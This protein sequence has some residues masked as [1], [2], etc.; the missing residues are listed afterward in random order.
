MRLFLFPLLFFGLPLAEIAGFVVV[1][2]WL[3]LWPT[4]GLVILSAFI[5]I[6]LLRQQGVSLLR[7]ISEES[8]Q[9][10]TP[11]KAIV[12]GAMMVVAAIL[13]II[14]GFLTDLIGIL[15]FLPPVRHS[16]W[17]R[18]GRAIVVRTSYSR[19]TAGGFG[20]G[21][22]QEPR[23]PPASRTIDL[24]EEDFERKPGTS[25]SPWSDR[26]LDDK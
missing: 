23:T 8:R 26:R 16:L 6:L 19:T 2:R 14:P 21:P 20:S 15:L 7:E 9:G 1:G 11:A 12:S 25:S 3:G 24:D 18:I 22:N 17:N 10:R 5:G 4:L 13:L